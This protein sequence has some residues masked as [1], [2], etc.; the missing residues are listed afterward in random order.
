MELEI[1]V[2][3]VCVQCLSTAWPHLFLKLINKLISGSGEVPFESLK[4][5]DEEARNIN[6][7]LPSS[8]E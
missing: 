2:K 3:Q 8:L 4:R 1:F 6:H 5:K 7:H